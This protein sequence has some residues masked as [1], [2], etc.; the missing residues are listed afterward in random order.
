MKV[1]H[2]LGAGGVGASGSGVGAPISWDDAHAIAADK[3][4]LLNQSEKASLLLGVGWN[5]SAPA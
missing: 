2:L 1:M 3:L 4:K 5:T